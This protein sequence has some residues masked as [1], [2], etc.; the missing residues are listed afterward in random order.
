MPGLFGKFSLI[1]VLVYIG[2]IAV[3]II[4]TRMLAPR[5]YD[6]VIAAASLSG[7]LVFLAII[8]LK[9]QS[10]SLRIVLLISSA[11]A[12]YDFWLDAFSKKSNGDET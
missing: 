12:I 4:A 5:Y 9:V 2:I 6:R 8:G 11:M 1:D 10:T 3:A 7:F